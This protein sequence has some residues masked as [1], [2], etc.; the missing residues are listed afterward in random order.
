M[1]AVV[2]LDHT[3]IREPLLPDASLASRAAAGDDLALRELTRRHGTTL[4]AIAYGILLDP[5]ASES[6]VSAVFIEFGKRLRMVGVPAMAVHRWLAMATKVR[7]QTVL[8]ERAWLCAPSRV[9]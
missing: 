9:R 2:A 7:A 1:A 5:L 8:P 3:S 4:Y 6:I